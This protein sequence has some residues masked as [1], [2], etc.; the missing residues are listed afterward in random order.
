M[1]C[2]GCGETQKITDIPQ[3]IPP[4][5]YECLCKNGGMEGLYSHVISP[6]MISKNL[7]LFKALSDPF[8]M[9]ILSLLSIQPLCVCIIRELLQ[10]SDTRLSYHLK[11]LSTLNLISGSPQGNW[12]IYT[13]TERGSL[14]LSL[15][16]NVIEP[17]GGD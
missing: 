12:I 7:K 8:R 11:K 5:V 1:K 4:L 13:I 15:C 9:K 17:S 16:L 6:D 3:N 14:A 10:I 2:S